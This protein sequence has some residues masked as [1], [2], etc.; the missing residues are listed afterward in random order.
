MIQNK[1][2]LITGGTGSFGSAVLKCFMHTEHFSEIRIFSRDEMKR[3]E[4]R[5]NL[6]SS[7]LKFY[8]GG[9]RD[10]SS[11]VPAMRGVD[12]VF[13]TA[14]LKQVPSCDFFPIQT[15]ITNVKGAQNLI[16]DV[17]CLVKKLMSLLFK[18]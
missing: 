15:V 9:G 17:S 6:M 2:L 5:N 18:C 1:T 4:M 13:H 12:F 16:H 14:V 7:K 3:D 11:L 10:Y 8:I